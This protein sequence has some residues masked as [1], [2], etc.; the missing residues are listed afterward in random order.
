VA[1]SK[2]TCNA[3]NKRTTFALRRSQPQSEVRAPSGDRYGETITR[4]YACDSC[5]ALNEMR[6][7]PAFWD[8]IDG[9]EY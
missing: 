2:F 8:I 1:L 6:Q 3:C 9:I 4:I 5:H 7:P